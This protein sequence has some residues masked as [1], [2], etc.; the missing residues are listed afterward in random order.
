MCVTQ[1]LRIRTLHWV[2]HISFDVGVVKLVLPSTS[3]RT[4]F[5]S[6]VIYMVVMRKNTPPRI[7]TNGHRRRL[8]IRLRKFQ[9]WVVGLDERIVSEICEMWDKHCRE[10]RKKPVATANS[11]KNQR[12]DFS[13]LL[14]GKD[15]RRHQEDGRRWSAEPQL[16]PFWLVWRHTEW[17]HTYKT[18]WRH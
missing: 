3:R 18:A 7:P 2:K 16:L 9:S 8:Y 4:A 13:P 15:F 17:N 6:S 1:A 5:L 12:R 14:T 11:C 10:S